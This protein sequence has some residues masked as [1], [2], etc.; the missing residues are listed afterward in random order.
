M[1]LQRV[2]N[3]VMEFSKGNYWFGR[4]FT[5]RFISP[6]R[7]GGIFDA[8]AG[9]GITVLSVSWGISNVVAM[10]AAALAI[11]SAPLT[12]LT[13]IAVSTVFLVLDCLMVGFGLGFLKAAYDKSG[14]APQWRS[15]KNSVKTAAKNTMT[16][17]KSA[18]NFG[19]KPSG[20]FKKSADRQKPAA[21]VPKPSPK[22]GWDL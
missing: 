7:A 22:Q 15:G 12:G 8:F 3:A 9:V 13:T 11:T 20:D 5:N 2:K 19:K 16:S 18:L 4:N 10:G 14:V 17:V 21:S 1:G 6:A